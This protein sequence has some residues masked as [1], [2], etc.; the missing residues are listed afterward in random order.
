M[1]STTICAYVSE[2]LRTSPSHPKYLFPLTTP[3]PQPHLTS[4]FPGLSPTPSKSS[5]IHVPRIPQ[6]SCPTNPTLPPTPTR[7]L[8]TNTCTRLV[9][10]IPPH[11]PGQSAT[12]RFTLK[13]TT[14][15]HPLVCTLL[16]Q[17]TTHASPPQPPYRKVPPRMPHPTYPRRTVPYLP[18]FDAPNSA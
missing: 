8:T 18:H 17:V 9:T 15:A 12:S 5:S 7:P 1:S 10:R 14:P 3:T 13:S 11:S 2:P 4:P 6:A 16:N